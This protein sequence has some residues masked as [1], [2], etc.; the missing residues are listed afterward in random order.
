[1]AIVATLSPAAH[2][3]WTFPRLDSAAKAKQAGTTVH[4]AVHQAVRPL[5][6]HLRLVRPLGSNR[7]PP[8]TI[9]AKRPP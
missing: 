9:L 5:G 6:N 7:P 1:L 3:A 2:A 4:P 8:K